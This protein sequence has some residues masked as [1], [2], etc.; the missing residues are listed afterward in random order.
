MFTNYID[1]EK[2]KPRFLVRKGLLEFLRWIACSKR[3]TTLTTRSVF[4]WIWKGPW[5]WS[6]TIW[7]LIYSSALGWELR[8][9]QRLLSQETSDFFLVVLWPWHNTFVTKSRYLSCK[10]YS[11]RVKFFAERNLVLSGLRNEPGD[12]QMNGHGLSAK[13]FQNS[14]CCNGW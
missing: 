11:Y 5:K 14:V 2:K 7:L 8:N 3:V 1:C 12:E 13:E 9:V 10:F 4:P 6:I